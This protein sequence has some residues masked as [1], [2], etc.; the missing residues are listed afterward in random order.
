MRGDGAA[1]RFAGIELNRR[2]TA[3]EWQDAG[4]SAE[5]TTTAAAR[6]QFGAAVSNAGFALFRFRDRGAVGAIDIVLGC[7]RKGGPCASAPRYD[8][9]VILKDDAAKRVGPWTSVGRSEGLGGT[10][11]QLVFERARS[12]RDRSHLS[13]GRRQEQ[14]SCCNGSASFREMAGLICSITAHNRRR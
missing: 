1:W 7:L 4:D 13:V 9:P 11:N 10:L 14:Q 3:S 2:L 8:L 5:L 12:L 6:S